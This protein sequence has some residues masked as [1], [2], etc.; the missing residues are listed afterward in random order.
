MGEWGWGAGRE[1]IQRIQP[2]V[3]HPVVWDYLWGGQNRRELASARVCF[4]CVPSGSAGPK[5]G[6]VPVKEQGV[7]GMSSMALGK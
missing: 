3:C 2:G 6:V 5:Q 4:C 7:S 1:A